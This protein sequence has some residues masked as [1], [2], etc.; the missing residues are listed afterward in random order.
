MSFSINKVINKVEGWLNKYGLT[1]FDTP[2]SR[3]IDSRS[4]SFSR[5]TPMSSVSHV[6]NPANPAN[7][8]YPNHFK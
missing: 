5:C 7:P 6:N 3:P 4:I 2:P 8:S 1:M